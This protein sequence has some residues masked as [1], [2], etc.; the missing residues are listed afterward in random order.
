MVTDMN[1]NVHIRYGSNIF[2]MLAIIEMIETIVYFMYIK[3]V[4]T[5]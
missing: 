4:F 2:V 3:L 1:N 5:I